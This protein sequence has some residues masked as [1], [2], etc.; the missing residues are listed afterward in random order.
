MKVHFIDKDDK[1]CIM[2]LCE[3]LRFFNISKNMKN[4]VEDYLFGMSCSE[5]MQK[6]NI[7]FETYSELV[8]T[9]EAGAVPDVT[10]E[11]T[12]RLYKLVLNVTNVCNL[13]CKYCYAGGGNYSSSECMMSVE[14]AQKAIDL[15][16]SRYKNIK[17]IQFFGGEPLLNEPVIR[18]SCEYITKLYREQAIESLPEFGLVTNGTVYSEEIADTIRK[19]NISVTI[20]VDGPLNV[21][22][23][24]RIYKSGSGTHEQIC[25]N[26]SKFRDKTVHINA[27]EVTYNSC[28]EK[29]CCSVIDTVKYIKDELNIPNVHI[30]PVSTSDP[31]LKITNRDSFIS[32]VS[33]VFEAI[34]T[35]KKDYSYTYISRIF[36]SLKLRKANKYL[37]EAGISSF[38]ISCK[39]DIYP[40]FMF[41]DVKEYKMGNVFDTVSPFESQLFLRKQ[42][43]FKEFSK[44]KYPKCKNCYINRIC[45]GCLG[46]NYYSCNDIYDTPEEECEMQRE[47][48]RRVLTELSNLL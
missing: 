21:H 12:D 35:Q 16:Y 22:D 46:T 32:S 20:S 8:K 19:F 11:S 10:A 4:V 24:M 28:H 37:C 25:N 39:G 43:T 6:H 38:S 29:C 47:L 7:S 33:D 18:F 48:V 45:S 3:S 1:T 5:I 44:Y 31:N 30:V 40:C 27:A 42:S 14:A 34:K 17:V 13:G 41:T 9:V 2:F 23:Q 15:F 36:Q 26:I